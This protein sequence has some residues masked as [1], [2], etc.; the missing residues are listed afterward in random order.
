V[1]GTAFIIGGFDVAIV[2][3]RSGKTG[4]ASGVPINDF[5][6][7][8]AA[9]SA[10]LVSDSDSVYAPALSFVAMDDFNRADNATGLGPNW[11]NSPDLTARG[12]HPVIV[13]NQ[14]QAN[15]GDFSTDWSTAY[16]NAS[17]F[18]NDQ[19]AQVV[20]VSMAPANSGWGAVVR[21][22]TAGHSNYYAFLQILTTAYLFRYDNGSTTQLAT[23]STASINIGDIL[24][25]E[26]SDNTLTAK[27]NGVTKLTATDTT[28]PSG[29][30]GLT[31]YP[32]TPSSPPRASLDNWSGGPIIGFVSNLLPNLVSDADV[33]YAPAVVPSTISLLPALFGDADTFYAPGV[34]AGVVSLSPALFVDTDAIYAPTA[35][36]GAATLLPVLVADPD[37]VYAASIASG[38]VALLP[39]LVSDAD[40]IYVPSFGA[41]DVLAPALVTAADTIFA[42]SLAAGAAA[43][44]P[45][46]VVDADAIFAGSLL[47]QATLA[48]SLVA[49]DDVIPAASVAPV[50]QP[51]AIA[52]DD[53]IYAASVTMVLQ[54]QLVADVDAIAATDVG[55]G[56]FAGFTDDIDVIYGAAVHAFNGLLP[57]FVDE[58]DEIDTYP[59]RVHALTG[60]IP[61]PPPPVRV[62]TGSVNQ[63]R[64]LTGSVNQRPHLIGSIKRK[65]RVLTGSLYRK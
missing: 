48:P 35:A 32:G 30:P 19:F 59:F 22:D 20:V 6:V 16:W 26:V 21:H 41:I 29:N 18:A 2:T 27:I 42:P 34:A 23:V 11:T 37:A 25:L 39:G 7:V 24:R 33:V 36:A 45:P 46:I 49:A 53:A 55:G 40:T 14:V 8:S 44:S 10:S 17:T 50:A 57:S 58:D 3:D 1:S 47:G 12:F 38:A 5:T 61:G 56:V 31:I 64:R 60:G 52:A 4:I 62:L 28:Y 65:G 63:R 54:P 13:S 43:V 51:A 9:L 15:S